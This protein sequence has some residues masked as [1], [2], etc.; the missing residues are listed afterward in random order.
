MCFTHVVKQ[1]FLHDE[2]RHRFGQLAA[3]LHR[4]QAQGDDLRGEQEVDDIRVINLHVS[5]IVLFN[6]PIILVLSFAPHILLLLVT[7]GKQTV[8]TLTSAPM[9]PKEVS[10]KYSNGRVL[11]E[12]FRKGY[13]N[14]GIWAAS[15]GR[16]RTK[17][18]GLISLKRVLRH[19]HVHLS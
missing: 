17:T 4:A 7:R 10:L 15:G 14:R 3:D 18:L 13:K 6:Q 9:T 5:G 1:N 16:E 19:E 8:R 12:V 11:L 2:R